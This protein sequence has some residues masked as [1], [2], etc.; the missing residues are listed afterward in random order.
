MSVYFGLYTPTGKKNT[1]SVLIFGQYPPI[2]Y[3][4]KTLTIILASDGC[5]GLDG[6]HTA[7]TQTI[8][9]RMQRKKRHIQGCQFT[10]NKINKIRENFRFNAFRPW[11][12]QLS[13]FDLEPYFHVQS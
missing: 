3:G 12:T 6:K 7:L 4:V 11:K 10:R 9:P 5:N 8:Q 13:P 1:S 2:F